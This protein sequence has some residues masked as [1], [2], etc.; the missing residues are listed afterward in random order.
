MRSYLG[1]QLV[2]MGVRSKVLVSHTSVTGASQYYSI[3]RQTDGGGGRLYDIHT[4]I[5][6][7][8]TQQK[9]ELI[10]VTNVV[11]IKLLKKFTVARALI[12]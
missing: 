6:L 9:Y 2:R 3:I 11:Y 7:L 8:H 10:H 5:H 12:T 1:H 4:N